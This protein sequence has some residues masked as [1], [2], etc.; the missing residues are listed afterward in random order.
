MAPSALLN[1]L[2]EARG[3]EHR[4]N[5]GRVTGAVCA[6]VIPAKNICIQ[7]GVKQLE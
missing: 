6:R 2:C 3:V 4:A 1:G 7:G 5:T